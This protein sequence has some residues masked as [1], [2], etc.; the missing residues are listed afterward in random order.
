METLTLPGIAQPGGAAARLQKLSPREREVLDM[1]AAGL[2]SSEAARSLFC[3]KRTVD[4]HLYSIYRKLG[5]SNRVQAAMA[6]RG[7]S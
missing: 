6:A 1:I 5:V 7:G 2:S 4:Y 3:S